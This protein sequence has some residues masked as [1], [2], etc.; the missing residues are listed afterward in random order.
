MVSVVLRSSIS[1]DERWS[2]LQVQRSTPLTDVGMI[3]AGTAYQTFDYTLYTHCCV[4]SHPTEDLKC[5][6]NEDRGS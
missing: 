6:V 2:W 5:A 3:G 4:E 1:C